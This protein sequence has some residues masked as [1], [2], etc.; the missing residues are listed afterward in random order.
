MNHSKVSAGI[1][2]CSWMEV[3]TF[4]VL[5]MPS[6]RTLMFCD[7]LKYWRII[8]TRGW[9]NVHLWQSQ[10][11]ILIS[12]GIMHTMYCLGFRLNPKH[13]ISLGNASTKTVVAVVQ[14]PRQLLKQYY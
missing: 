14:A 11:G 5:A 7:L 9:S 3:L 10:D 1:E 2:C 6:D 12:I 4:V 13:S 8:E